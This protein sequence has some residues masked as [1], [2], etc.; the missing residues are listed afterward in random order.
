MNKKDINRAFLSAQFNASNLNEEN[1]VV[2]VVWHAGSRMR[3]SDFLI[4]NYE[5]QLSMEPEAIDL[6]LFSSGK[7]PLLK[8]HENELDSVVGVVE[9]AWLDGNEG[10]ALVRFDDDDE[11]ERLYKKVK[12]RIINNISIGVDFLQ[13][14]IVERK[15]EPD[16]HF[17]TKWQPYEISL[18]AVGADSK[19]RIQNNYKK[20]AIMNINNEQKNVKSSKE[21]EASKE[22]LART[23][24][25]KLYV[26]M[27][28]LQ[29]EAEKLARAKAQKRNDEIVEI[30]N[31]FPAYEH[32]KSDFL[33]D[34]S[35]SPEQAR[36]KLLEELGKNTKPINTNINMAGGCQTESEKFSKVLEASIARKAGLPVEDG[37]ETPFA[38]HTLREM[39][40][41]YLRVNN[42]KITNNVSKDV[43]TAFSEK[44]A[45]THSTSDFPAI[46]ENVANKAMLKGYNNG[47]TDIT[48]LVNKTSASDFKIMSRAG[49]SQFSN[50]AEVGESGE[51]KYGTMD[52]RKEL[53]QLLTYARLFSISR[54]GIIND[55][56]RM[57]S[58][59]PQRLGAA[60]RRQT[61]NLVATVLA[62]GKN[63]NM[64]DGLALWHAATHKNFVDSG[65]A[66]SAT[67]IIAALKAMDAQKDS[68]S[69]ERLHIKPKY[70]VV[71]RALEET[72][73][74]WLEGQ[75]DQSA[76][77]TN[78]NVI[79]TVRGKADLFVLPELA[80]VTGGDETAWYMLA[81]PAIYDTIELSFLDGVET[82]YLEQQQGWAV[83]GLEFK[84][85]IDVGCAPMDYKTMYRNDGA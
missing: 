81:D 82:P 68:T 55:D 17:V 13:K 30:F 44:L 20:E 40:R 22:V 18:V 75:F 46:L 37:I 28:N 52:D 77:N 62:N 51:I 19:A 72:A 3:R 4:G 33:A 38:G 39:A 83:D 71:P 84:V 80:S 63:I 47:G 79:N 6:S 66:P 29:K 10:K 67:T 1:R 85:R 49:L 31:A 78:A 73:M 26:D 64:S 15:G 7:T 41:E 16:L 5:L 76:A 36:V 34:T 61:V 11:G 14:E 8:D 45:I 54:Q 48:P 24:T 50:L 53:I 12:N 74:Q 21:L 23:E 35:I 43:S 59:I 27:E 32:L 25:E 2:E 42:L 9:K 56:M 58:T 69:N 57:F 65:A 70:L 60:A